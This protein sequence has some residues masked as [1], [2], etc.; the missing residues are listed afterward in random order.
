[1]MALWTVVFQEVCRP[2]TD[3]ALAVNGGKLK[4]SSVLSRDCILRQH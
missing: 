3:A 4:V 2:V 1:M